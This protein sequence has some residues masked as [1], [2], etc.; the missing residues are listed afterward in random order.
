MKNIDRH[1]LSARSDKCRFV[2]YPKESI[3]FYFY[4][5]T[6]QKVFVGRHVSFLEKEFNQKGDSERT[7]ELEKVLDL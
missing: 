2:G 6:Q 5:P 1:K 3:G 7:V 4:H